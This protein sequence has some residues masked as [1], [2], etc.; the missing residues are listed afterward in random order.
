MRVLS[1]SVG[2][3]WALVAS[4]FSPCAW[5]MSSAGQTAIAVL[6]P[7]DRVGSGPA[8]EAMSRTLD[9]ELG[10][11]GRVLAP[12]PTR[13]ALRRLRLRNR[14]A[15][16]QEQLQRLGKELGAGWL[17]SA[18]VHDASG[19]L[20]PNITLSVRVYSGATGEALWAGFAGGSGLDGPRILGLGVLEDLEPLVTAVTRKLLA[21]LPAQTPA[22]EATPGAPRS[23]GR[24]ALV[25]LSASTVATATRSAETV[26]EAVRARL[27]RSGIPLVSA[28][29]V[30]ESIRRYQDG[31]WG[32]ITREARIDLHDEAG[33]RFVL[34][35][36]VEAYDVPGGTLAPRPRVVVAMRLLDAGSGRIVWMDSQE[37]DE[38]GPRLFGI[39]RARSAG[40]AASRAVETL[41]ARLDDE[42][43]GVGPAELP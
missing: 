43:L 13:D 6:P 22:I 31:R 11:Y 35:G 21:S 24:V 39:G 38:A 8:V 9:A 42:G 1:G 14:D 2:I 26:T 28:G 40:E 33:A 27:L 12:G 41:L 18:T 3:I 36:A 7:Q 32:G 23:T 29:R 19:E 25:P 16:P 30:Q 10:R 20:Y 34:T 17:V 5:G 4:A 15:A 37:Q